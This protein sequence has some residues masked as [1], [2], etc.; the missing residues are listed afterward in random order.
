[1]SLWNQITEYADKTGKTSFLLADCVGIDK[2]TDAVEHEVSRLALQG[3]IEFE[4]N[5]AG[6]S[7]TIIK[8]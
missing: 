3:F 4:E 7:I 5:I 8:K 2:L 1:M 6:G